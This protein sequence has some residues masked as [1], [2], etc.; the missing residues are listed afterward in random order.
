[1]IENTVL[2]HWEWW[3]VWRSREAL[4]WFF[5]IFLT[6]CYLYLLTT[7]SFSVTI[8]HL[9]CFISSTLSI[10]DN[11]YSDSL[12]T[13]TRPKISNWMSHNFLQLNHSKA[14]VRINSPLTSSLTLKRTWRRSFSHCRICCKMS[15]HFGNYSSQFPRTKAN[16]FFKIASFVQPAVN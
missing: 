12:C 3:W 11:R 13:F 7:S 15:Q 9:V 4:N 10:L 16:I 6:G 2:I 8:H 5:L 1:M 14:E